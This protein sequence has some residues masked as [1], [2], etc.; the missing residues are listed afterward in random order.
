M[1]I[2]E[3]PALERVFDAIRAHV[4]D[5][6]PDVDPSEITA[7]RSLA[8]LGANSIDRADIVAMT[9][10]DLGISVPV[11]EFAEVTDV[12]SLAVLLRRHLP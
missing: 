12:G 3:D 8:D 4:I 5:V 7:E 10:E 6:L 2:T 9:Q 11:T 1:Q